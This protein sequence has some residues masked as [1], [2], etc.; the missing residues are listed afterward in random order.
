[1]ENVD[2]SIIE[3]EAE[4]SGLELET[5]NNETE[6][7]TSNE[8]DRTKFNFLKNQ[9]IYMS[10]CF[11]VIIQCNLKRSF[12]IV[13]KFILEQMVRYVNGFLTHMTKNH[14]FAHYVCVLLHC[15][16]IVPSKVQE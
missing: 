4:N 8:G 15:L 12:L 11:Y 3:I 14:Y 10:K 5:D 9:E 16:E 1:M 13:Q 6:T 7:D 2:V